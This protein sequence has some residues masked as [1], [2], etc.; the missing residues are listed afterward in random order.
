MS[1]FVAQVLRKSFRL[2]HGRE[3]DDGFRCASSRLGSFD[4]MPIQWPASVM[5]GP[6]GVGFWLG[7]GRL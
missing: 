7:G 2:P 1:L 4:S 6:F 5:D 3:Y